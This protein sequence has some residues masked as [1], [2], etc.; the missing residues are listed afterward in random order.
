[1]ER[2]VYLLVAGKAV[3]KEVRL[4]ASSDTMSVV[5][6]G[7]VKQGDQVILNPPSAQFGP[8]NGPRGGFGG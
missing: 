2:V 3:K 7:D 1:G 5:A 6:V 4:G 8:G